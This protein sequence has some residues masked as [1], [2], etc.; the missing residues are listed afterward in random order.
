[1]E[2]EK[3]KNKL[4]ESEYIFFSHLQKE[5]DLPLFFIG[6]ITRS[7][8][9]KNKSDFDIEVFSNNIKSTK[10][11]IESLFDYYERKNENKIIVFKIND[12]PMSGYK[13]YLKDKTKNIKMD[14]TIYKKNCQEILLQNRYIDI[15]IPFLLTI[16][17]VILK[18][19]YY[20][21]NLINSYT[22]SYLKK[23]IWK[24]YNN[25]KTISKTYTF[26]EYKE[27]YNKEYMNSENKEYLI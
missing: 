25:K 6:S 13:Y 12:I 15:N 27:L 4:N 7:D 21:L 14:F 1:M 20:Y 10:L 19:L 2:L 17:F 9:I 23:T 11:K 24:I 22:Y 16:I 3:I 5:L 18:Y 26:T 8:Y